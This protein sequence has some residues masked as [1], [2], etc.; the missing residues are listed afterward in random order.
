MTSPHVCVSTR[1]IPFQ[2]CLGELPR[3]FFLGGGGVM[4][5]KIASTVQP[6]DVK[7]VDRC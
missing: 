2:K 7:N 6:G 4:R 3:I 1:V 5:Q